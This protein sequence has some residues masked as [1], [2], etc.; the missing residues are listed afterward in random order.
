[1]V[2]HGGDVLVPG[3]GDSLNGLLGFDG[4]ELATKD[5]LEIERQGF[6]A[7]LH[8][9]TGG[10]DLLATEAHLV[11]GTDNLGGDIIANLFGCQSCLSLLTGPLALQ[12]S[13]AEAETFQFPD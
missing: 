8:L 6:G 5:P 7:R 10:L 12:C 2:D 9:S 13:I 3:G 1:M 11:V 4:P